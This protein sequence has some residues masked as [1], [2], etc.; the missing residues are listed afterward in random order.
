MVSTTIKFAIPTKRLSNK[1]EESGL[2]V[3]VGRS[4][5]NYNLHNLSIGKNHNIY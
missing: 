4:E 3:G 1:R 5:E 2:E